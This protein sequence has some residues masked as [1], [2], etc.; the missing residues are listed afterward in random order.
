MPSDA[1]ND[2]KTLL[3]AASILAGSG[4]KKKK[5]GSNVAD[6]LKS[7]L[8]EFNR[9]SGS[10]EFLSIPDGNPEDYIENLAASGA[11]EITGDASVWLIGR[12]NRLLVPE[13]GTKTISGRRHNP[14]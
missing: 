10:S 11:E 13:N 5:I 3:S 12:L 14:V 8:L 6:V 1:A 9:T 2:L 4:E 7:R